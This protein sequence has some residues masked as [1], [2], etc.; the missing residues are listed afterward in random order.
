MNRIIRTLIGDL[1]EKKTY[2][3]TEKRAKALPPEYA[4]AYKEMKH[5]LWNTSGVTTITPLVSLV[6]LLEEAAAT[7]KHV[8]DV[9]GSDVAAFVDDLTRDETSYKN[10]QAQKLNEKLAK[11]E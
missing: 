4:N 3:L 5:Y 1:N 8:I 7:N 10:K 2:R 11:N 6:D 9:I